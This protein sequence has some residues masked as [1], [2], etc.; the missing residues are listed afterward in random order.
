[1][2]ANKPP[3]IP[4]ERSQSKELLLGFSGS[5]GVASVVRNLFT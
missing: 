4:S 5:S 3:F 1:M 2:M